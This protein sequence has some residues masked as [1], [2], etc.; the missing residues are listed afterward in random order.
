M[1][2][3]AVLGTAV[4]P[5]GWVWLLPELSVTLVDDGYDHVLYCHSK[6]ELCR[7]RPENSSR[8]SASVGRQF[9]CFFNHI[10][11]KQPKELTFSFLFS[12]ML[13]SKLYPVSHHYDEDLKRANIFLGY[14]K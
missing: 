9:I 8:F 14:I 13:V 12:N 6:P 5:G 7:Y 4:T 10:V 2:T 3:L 11:T 1:F